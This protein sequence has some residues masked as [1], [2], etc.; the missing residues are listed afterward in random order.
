MY[1]KIFTYSWNIDEKETE[2]TCIRV[3]GLDEYNKN[4]CIRI[5]NFTPYVYV[6][7]PQ[8]INWSEA[9]SQLV[10][11]KINKMLD[12][13]K[14]LKYCL[15]WKKKLYGAYLD[16]NGERMK[17]PFLFLSFSNRSDIKSLS[18]KLRGTMYIAG[19]G[20]L[21]L[22]VHESDADPI[23]QLVCCRNLPTAG[24]IKFQGK[25]VCDRDKI[26]LCDHE[27]E[28]KWK[29]IHPH[30]SDIFPRPKI[31]GFDIEVNSTNPSAM[32]KAEKPGDKIFQISC[33]I[34]R[35]GDELEKYEKYLLTLGQPDPEV[36]GEDVLIYMYESEALLL[37]GFTNFLREENPNII[38]GY[39]ILGF[40]IPYM[41][42]RAKLN[43]CISHFDRQGFHKEAHSKERII[44]WSSSAYK[45]QEFEFLDA[46]GRIY[47]DLLPLVRRDFKFNNYKLKTISEYFLKGDTKDPLS[48]QGIFKCYRIGITKNANGEYSNK[49]QKAMAICGKYCV[50]DSV[51]V[52]QLMDKLKTWVGL[53]EMA[54]VSNVGVFALYTQGQQIKVYSTLYKYCLY[55]GIVVEKDGYQVAD[56]ERY[57]GAKVF[58]P[59]PGIYKMVVPFD[60]S[61]LY[62][63]TIIAYNIDYHTWVPP[64]SD[65]PDN[66]CHVMEW[67]EHIS[68]M[69]DPKIIRKLELTK[70][71]DKEKDK[72]KQMRDKRN[73][74]ADKIRKK[75]LME[76]I[77]KKLE[78]LKPYVE[79]RS[80]IAKTINKNITC[81]RRKYRFIKEPRGVLPTVIQNLLDARKNTRK[82]DMKKCKKEIERLL[83]DTRENGTDNKALIS[84]QTTLLDVLDKRQLA[85]KVGA[86][87]MYGAMGVRRGYLPFMPGAM[88]TTYMGRTNIEIVA[89]TIPEKYGG[90]LVYGDTDTVLATTPVLIL[91]NNEICYT[92]LENLSAGDWKKTVT[93]KELSSPKD[94][95]KVWSDQGFTEIKYVMRHAI[96]KP[97]IKVTTHTGTIVCTLDHSL[98]W[99]N[100]EPALGSEIKLRDKLCHRN[101]PLPDDTPKEPVYPN[102]LTAE[103]IREYVISDDVYED[104]SADLAFVWGVFFAD[105]SCGYPR[106]DN[107]SSVNTWVIN[108]KDNTLLER[109]LNILIKYETELDFKILDTMN[110]LVAKQKS[111]KK[112]DNGTINEFLEKYR[113][114]FYDNRKYKKVPDIV[115]N[116]PYSI[117]EA[118]FMGYFAGDGSK[119]DPSLTITNKGEIGCAGLFFLLRSIGYQVS[120]N[121]HSDKPDTYKLTSSTPNQ[122]FRYHPNAVKKIE[123][124]ET[125][126]KYIYD[127]ETSNHHFAAGVGQLV[128]HNS[129]YIHFPHLKSAQET[130]DYAVHV[131]SEV[132]KLFPRP[133]ELEFEEEIYSFFFILSKKRY[134]YRKCLRDGVV[135]DKIG[136]KG[137]LLAR[138][139]NSKFVRDIYEEII[140][141]IADNVP[142][143]DI[144]YYAISQINEACSGV[145]EINDFVVT[146]AVGNSGGLLPEAFTNEK[147]I[148]KAKVGDY[149]VPILSDDPKER[150]EQLN[151]KSAS[152]D[153][154]YYLLS[155]P[156][157]VQLAERMRNRGQRVDSGT[158]LEY[159][160]CDPENHNA[161]QYEKIESAEYVAKHG[162]YVKIDYMYYVKALINPLDQVLDV[163]FGKE[164]GYSKGFVD[165]QHKFRVKIRHKL[166][167]EL[168][169][170]FKPKLVFEK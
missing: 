29:N 71:I 70:Y 11:E 99:E 38:V 98:L 106:K 130:W 91:K 143:D 110:K 159:I 125:A 30:E 75:E 63:T 82:V 84:V 28:V 164:K 161:K 33:V 4:V 20:N 2:V 148:I 141:K 44:K 67:D 66:M 168:K 170:L 40:D 58:P 144:L 57:M 157:Q 35:D 113:D 34:A 78:E 46:E 155:L 101:L 3:Y 39:N 51:L 160:I 149:T 132:T 150:E 5:D 146:K 73:K 127:I 86:N 61:S 32:P 158:R 138:R 89:K 93:G 60:F 74:T 22:K 15:Q 97:M 95:I 123:P 100:G 13:Q 19:M 37:E 104:L 124:Y 152:T 42:A 36:T 54:T 87:S 109:C 47:V 25:E 45:N 23:L 108:K 81:T 129:N 17:F 68:C 163:A 80:E 53:T 120:I 114:L 105:G 112:E 48:P 79:E 140:G 49:A 92:T 21:Q 119:K 50:K 102:N 69:H 166:L 1:N 7:L 117:R 139:D 56:N 76:D 103:K 133:I 154:E 96:E 151:K 142:K 121:T 107:K 94:G 136:K 135:E 162:E 137:V 145:K 147:G 62:P 59:V 14:P 153:E 169:E 128:V 41:I 116:A 27:Y 126:D 88:C 64:E 90:E 26:T 55:E 111:I 115:L 18:Y 118:F 24:W 10:V 31:M 72:I 65:I 12:R 16:E 156:A 134:M 122:K 9:K 165:K 43:M 77:D 131:A 52:V 83:D 85:Y 167:D 6:E 8:Y